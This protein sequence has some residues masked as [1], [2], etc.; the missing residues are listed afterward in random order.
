[1]ALIFQYGSNVS[2]R[3][4]NSRA[5]L[6]GDARM[7]GLV[8]TRGAFELGFTV[9]SDQNGCAAADIL[10]D[11]TRQIWGVLYQVPDHLIRR[12]TAGARRSFDAIENEGAEYLR[13]SVAVSWP[14]GRPVEEEVQTYMVRDRRDGLRTELHYVEH[15]LTGLLE[16]GAPEDYVSYVG[17]RIV[18]NNPDLAGPLAAHFPGLPGASACG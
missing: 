4:L 6:R 1:M 17:R 5:R 14:D 11:G 7:L 13:R 3:R 12:E 18:A 10:P 16:C 9:W 2:V 8:K 15:I